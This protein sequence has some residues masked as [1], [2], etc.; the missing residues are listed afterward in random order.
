MRRHAIN[1][2]PVL[3]VSLLCLDLEPAEAQSEAVALLVGY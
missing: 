3:A 2:S 1:I